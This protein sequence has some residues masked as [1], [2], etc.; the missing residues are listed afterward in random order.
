[1]MYS[2][3]GT[4][5]MC[6]W[7]VHA[8]QTSTNEC[9]CPDGSRF[10]LFLVVSRMPTATVISNCVVTPRALHARGG[11]CLNRVKSCDNAVTPIV[12]RQL[13]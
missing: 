11:M 8:Q 7:S 5:M 13:P 2:L 4:A 9:G 6:G 3:S 1:M 10:G 12:A